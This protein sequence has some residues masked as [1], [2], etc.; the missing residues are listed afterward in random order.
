MKQGIGI[1]RC[2]VFLSPLNRSLGTLSRADFTVLFSFNT[3]IRVRH[4]V[5]KLV[6]ALYSSSKYI[7]IIL[8]HNISSVEFNNR[9]LSGCICY[10]LFLVRSVDL[11][12]KTIKQR[13]FTR[14][15]VVYSCYRFSRL[16][17]L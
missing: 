4:I 1:L 9:C 7:V 11:R 13:I 15:L 14:L 2:A 12:S 17:N 6:R 3:F 16:L 8:Q 10:I 5:I